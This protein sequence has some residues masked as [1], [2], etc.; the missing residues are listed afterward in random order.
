MNSNGF[1]Q[2]AHQ[3]YLNLETSRKT[4]V[5]VATPVWFAEAHGTFYIY[6][7]AHAGKVKRIRN[8]AQV[9]IVPCDVR[10]TPKGEWV[11]AQARILDAHGAARGH[12]LLNEKYG[13]LKRLGDAVSRLRRRQR[14]VI[15]I[16]LV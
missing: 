14:V 9:R 5:P 15:A 4:G 8:N 2:F 11:T 16:E 3:Q 6:S 12:Q 1:I 7:L 13:W 10:G